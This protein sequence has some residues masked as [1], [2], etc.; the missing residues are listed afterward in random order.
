MFQ[1]MIYSLVCG[2]SSGFTVCSMMQSMPGR[3]EWHHA[4]EVTIYRFCKTTIHFLQCSTM[5]FNLKN[6][7][8][9]LRV[10]LS[11]KVLLLHSRG[12]LFKALLLNPRGELFK[13]LLLHPRGELFEALQ[14]CY[15]PKGV[16]HTPF[17]N[18]VHTRR[19]AKLELH[20][21]HVPRTNISV[22]W[23]SWVD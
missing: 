1:K 12:E 3:R 18:S 10:C 14:S 5:T 16:S 15:T 20:E 21:A 6:A 13:A 2:K 22:K 11:F 7:W 19:W 8:T 23:C 9:T 17:F 4:T